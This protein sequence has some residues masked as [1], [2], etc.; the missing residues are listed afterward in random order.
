MKNSVVIDLEQR[1]QCL[2]KQKNEA[3]AELHGRT[4]SMSICQ[5]NSLISLAKV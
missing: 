4:C 1:P 2:H 5:E 3:W